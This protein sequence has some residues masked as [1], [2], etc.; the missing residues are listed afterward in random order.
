MPV[1]R[2]KDAEFL[3]S[4]FAETLV[5]PVRIVLFTRETGGVIVPGHPDPRY[6]ELTH[7]LLAELAGL[8]DRL[9][10]D[11]HDIE[12][13]RDLADEYR[14]DKVP[15]TILVTPASR[16][17]RFFGLPAGYELAT[18]VEDLA[19]LS[20]GKTRLSDET[21]AALKALAGPLHIQVFVTPTC[22]YCPHAVRLAHQMAMES[23]RVLADMVEVTA[24][25]ELAERY[26]VMGVPKVVI[27][28]LVEFEGALPEP[29]FL[30]HVQAAD[31]ERDPS[32]A[33]RPRA[34]S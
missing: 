3:R 12:Q 7:L 11:V 28:D 15:A 29:A 5:T 32:H 25:P 1:L 19:D 22:P 2:P 13:D 14:V 27:N 6:L 9:S 16:G 8:S 26:G 18:L 20:G 4:R 34:R 31:A 23:D 17:V 24:F 10:L 30:A 33:P 21:R